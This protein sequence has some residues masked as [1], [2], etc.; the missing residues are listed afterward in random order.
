M[1]P[2]EICILHVY[3]KTLEQEFCRV[4]KRCKGK[5]ER[6]A[7][8]LMNSRQ[9]MEDITQEIFLKLWL[10]WPVLNTML[11]NALEDYIYAM[12]KNHVIDL[13]KRE[14]RAKN[15]IRDYAETQAGDYWPD[16]IVLLEGFKIYSEAIEQLP[17]KEKEVYLLYDNDLDRS[18]IANK[19]QRSKNTVNNQLYSASKTVKNYFQKKLNL[20]IRCDGRKR[21]LKAA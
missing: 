21:V 11:E 5:I 8:F 9:Q 3:N 6:K 14:S 18:A 19:M 7:F 20:K 4:Y 12:V 17:S 1:K 10:K 13:Q 15:I 2:S 16:E